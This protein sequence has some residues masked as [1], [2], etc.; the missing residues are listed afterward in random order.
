MGLY[1]L[2]DFG[3]VP[4]HESKAYPAAPLDVKVYGQQVMVSI[5]IIQRSV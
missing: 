3:Q 4:I 5:V 1:V 2:P